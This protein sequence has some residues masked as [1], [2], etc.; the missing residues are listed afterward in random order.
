M[1]FLYEVSIGVLYVPRAGG[2][3]VF[4]QNFGSTQVAA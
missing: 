4:T 3:L 2:I 1:R